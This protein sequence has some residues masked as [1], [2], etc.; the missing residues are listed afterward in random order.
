MDN[1]R[2]FAVLDNLVDLIVVCMEHPAAANQ[3]FLAGDGEDLST[4]EWLRQVGFALGKPARLV[5]VPVSLMSR[6]AAL[7]GKEAVARLL[8]AS[9]QV[10]ITRPNR[11]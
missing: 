10:D 3:V 1:L 5:P 7:L 6:V 11:C 2:S 4:T 8:F 9:L